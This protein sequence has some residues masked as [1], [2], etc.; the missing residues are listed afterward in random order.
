MMS[1][2]SM[3]KGEIEAVGGARA[4]GRAAVIS[5]G[6]ER[7][8]RALGGPVEAADTDFTAKKK[9]EGPAERLARQAILSRHPTLI[10]HEDCASR[11]T[12]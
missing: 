5:P 9:N 3:L 8:A 6:T 4:L 12:E 1:I 11:T 7:E 2:S 10:L